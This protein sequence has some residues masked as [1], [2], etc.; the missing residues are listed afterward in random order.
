MTPSK[1]NQGNKSNFRDEPSIKFTSC[2]LA[3][4]IKTSKSTDYDLVKNLISND[5]I[6]INKG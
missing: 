6:S 4:H 3:S 1:F 5:E 2:P